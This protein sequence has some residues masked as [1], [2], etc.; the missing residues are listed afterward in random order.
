MAKKVVRAIS[1]QRG[2]MVEMECI[3]VSSVRGEL[4]RQGGTDGTLRIFREV[5]FIGW[6]REIV[7]RGAAFI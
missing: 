6:I 2:R 3:W 1:A 5:G 4:Y 7:L